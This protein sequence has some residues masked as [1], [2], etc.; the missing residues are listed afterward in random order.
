[1]KPEWT[2]E[3][4]VTFH[5]HFSRKILPAEY[6]TFTRLGVRLPCDTSGNSGYAYVLMKASQ[7]R[8]KWSSLSAG[9]CNLNVRAVRSSVP[10]PL[11]KHNGCL[12]QLTLRYCGLHG[13]NIIHSFSQTQHET[14]LSYTWWYAFSVTWTKLSL[15][16]HHC[17]EITSDEPLGCQLLLGCQSSS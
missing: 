15:S 11:H 17:Y 16:L 7:V 2:T 12:Q 14:S 6:A 13:I 1:M 10:H 8:T 4:T 3:C 5:L 9:V